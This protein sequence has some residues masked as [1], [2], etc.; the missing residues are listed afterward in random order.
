MLDFIKSFSMFKKFNTEHKA[1]LF[2][3]LEER[4]FPK[5]E[6]I[7]REGETDHTL[8]LVY[9]GSA[10]II[11][12]NP[13]GE[14]IEIAF[15]PRGSYFGE[16]SLIDSQ[17]RSASITAFDDCVCYVL[18]Q[19]SYSLLCRQFPE[20]EAMML[21]GFIKDVSARLRDTNEIYLRY[22]SSTGF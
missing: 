1:L 19:L 6:F 21:H 15:L 7:I 5:D 8:F 20:T 10:N 2:K 13:H 3:L 17:P 18:T 12:Q 22:L 9:S 4:S 16:L 11:K 14:W